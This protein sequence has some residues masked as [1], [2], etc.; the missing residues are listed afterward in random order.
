M[1]YKVILADGEVF[2]TCPCCHNGFAT[3]R[4]A[5]RV[6]E[7]SPVELAALRMITDG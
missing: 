3:L 2:T 6:A 4:A 1:R 5:K 7:A